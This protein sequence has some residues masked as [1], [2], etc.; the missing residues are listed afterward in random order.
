MQILLGNSRN[1][2]EISTASFLNN[3]FTETQ[4]KNL[5]EK[6]RHDFYHRILL[7]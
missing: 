7:S 6:R 2:A 5:Y 3:F 1:Q 4:V